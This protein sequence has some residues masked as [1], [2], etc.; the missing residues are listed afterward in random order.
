M[1]IEDTLKLLLSASSPGTIEQLPYRWRREDYAE[2]RA[3]RGS[4][5][6]RAAV[7]GDD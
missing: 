7:L 5:L 3:G 6:E 2:I 1:I 4:I